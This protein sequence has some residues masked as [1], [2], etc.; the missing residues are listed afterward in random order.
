MHPT[1]AIE[2]P[3]ETRLDTPFFSHLTS[4]RS[5]FERSRAGG[6]GLAPLERSPQEKEWCSAGPLGCGLP[7]AC[8]HPF[9]LLAQ[10]GR[11]HVL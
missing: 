6:G 9:P 4:S 11:Y 5:D 7:F 2:R 10:V 3:E 8:H 1:R